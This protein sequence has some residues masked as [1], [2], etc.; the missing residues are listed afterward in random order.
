MAIYL[1]STLISSNPTGTG[2]LYLGS[3]NIC[4]AYLENT[5]VFDNCNQPNTSV[6]L[7]VVNAVTGG[8]ET[9]V[10]DL[11]GATKSGQPGTSF[12]A[13]NTSV[14]LATYYSWASGPTFS[15]EVGGTFPATGS[16]SRTTTVGG[17]TTYSP[18]P[19]T[20][21]YTLSVTDNVGTGI[22][23]QINGANPQ[24]G[25]IGSSSYSWTI[26][27][28][29]AQDYIVGT[30][31]SV[32][33]GT[34]IPSGTY[35]QGQSFTSQAI[36]GTISQTTDT[37]NATISGSIAPAEFQYSYTLTNQVANSTATKT[38]TN[39]TNGATYSASS[40][41]ITGTPGSTWDMNG[42]ATPNT[43]YVWSGGTQPA[44]AN[45]TVSATMPQNSNGSTTITLTGTTVYS[46]PATSIS[47]NNNAGSCSNDACI[48]ASGSSTTWWYS[49]SLQGATLWSNSNLTGSNPAGGWYKTGTS[50]TLEYNGG[51]SSSGNFCYSSVTY[52]GM[53]TGGTSTNAC[54]DNLNDYYYVSGAS[55]SAN[56]ASAIWD[57]TSACDGAGSGYY[58]WGSPRT[59]NQ[60]NS[61]GLVI[62]V[63]TC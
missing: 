51:V 34:S 30:A 61:S 53:G 26:T 5:Q 6:V 54:N 28:T 46:N 41:L 37:I 31:I 59:W 19:S 10:G 15:G 14:S 21:T 2:A 1:G 60:T 25:T 55:Y 9:L 52:V 12:T 35:G 3:L 44:S 62:N 39:L 45:Q 4:D 58:S 40:N 49:G 16:I 42:E 20:G 56:A 18:P 11:T 24:T 13:F 36:T 29:L 57:D 63:G 8:G 22:S 33:G 38:V 43:N 47:L 48:A 32:N 27:I 17:T 7:T 23:Y 50:S